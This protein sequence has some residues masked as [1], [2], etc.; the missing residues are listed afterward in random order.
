MSTVQSTAKQRFSY[1]EWYA[2][3]KERLAK[4]K[5]ERYANDPEYREKAKLR[6][7]NRN[8]QKHE[9][10]QDG[11]DISFADAAE[12]LGVTLWVLREWRRKSYFPEPVVRLGSFRFNANQLELLKT[13]KTFFDQHGRKVRESTRQALEEK[14]AF[15]YANW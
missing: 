13:L 8:K 11:F 12:A 6:S 15:V 5:K 3:N 10:P 14:V 2:A 4:K 9:I 7:K 1:K